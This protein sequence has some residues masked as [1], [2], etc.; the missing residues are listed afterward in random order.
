MTMADQ[1]AD[2]ERRLRAAQAEVADLTRRLERI[3]EALDRPTSAEADA[4]LAFHHA[5]GTATV[6]AA[7]DP[8]PRRPRGGHD[9]FDAAVLAALG[10]L[11]DSDVRVSLIASHVEWDGGVAA[12]DVSAA[13]Q[14]LKR[15]KDVDVRPGA[16][17]G[18]WRLV[19]PPEQPALAVNGA[20]P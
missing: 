11:G 8:K 13:C 5:N 16:K 14:R 3:R 6:E 4:A 10:R 7:A 1:V 18:Y 17:T 2:L 19:V 15:R 9:A 20:Q 12:S